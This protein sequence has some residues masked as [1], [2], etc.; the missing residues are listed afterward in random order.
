MT[1]STLFIADLHLNDAQPEITKRFKDFLTNKARNARALYILGDLF[2]YYL[3]DDAAIGIA[4]DI[5]NELKKLSSQHN[6]QCYFM[7]G[8]RDFLLSSDFAKKSQLTLLD[9]STAIQ[10]DQ[11]KIILTHGDAL[12]TDDH[13]YQ[14]IRQQ[15]RS[16]QWQ[17]WFLDQ[18]IQERIAFAKQARIQSQEH[19]QTA[20]SE[21]MDVNQGAV[22]ELFKQYNTE[23]MIHGHTHRP[24]FHIDQKP[25]LERQRMVV[26]DWHYQTSYIEY[27]NNNFQLIAC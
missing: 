24:A 9:D 11:H 18:T 5:C 3:G 23:Y 25:Q 26:G 16:I 20:G 19:T 4:H 15:L 12:C 14:K 10:L 6:T 17:Q 2:E 13:A 1:Q 21:I 7:P 27:K 22:D 8:N